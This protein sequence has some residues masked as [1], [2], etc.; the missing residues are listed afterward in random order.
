M[1]DNLISL[2]GVICTKPLIDTERDGEQFYQFILD[3]PGEDD[4]ESVVPV[5]ISEKL[6]IGHPDPKGSIIHL[7]GYYGIVTGWGSS[8]FIDFNYLRFFYPVDVRWE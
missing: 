3:C 6:L 4:K 7:D 2:D 1:S 5:V 8:S